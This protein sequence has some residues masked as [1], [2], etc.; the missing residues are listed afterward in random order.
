MIHQ[1]VVFKTES[2]PYCHQARAFLEA[3]AK[4]RGD[5]QVKFVDANGNPGAFQQVMRATRRNTVP[6]IFLGDKF[7][8]GWDDLARAAGNG[9][10][11]AY[12]SGEPLPEP[13]QEPG[14]AFVAD[15]RPKRPKRRWFRRR[16]AS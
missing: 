11:D 6:Q 12:L 5:V 14:P 13:A 2:C 3:L 1:F 7:I 10:L 8:G 9:K 16:T 4:E 15:E